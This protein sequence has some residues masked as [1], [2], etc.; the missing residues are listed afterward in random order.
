MVRLLYFNLRCK[1][2][3]FSADFLKRF[4]GSRNVPSDKVAKRFTPMSIPIADIDL[5]SRIFASY[6][7]RGKLNA[8]HSVSINHKYQITIEFI[9]ED[10][11]L[12]PIDIS[13]HCD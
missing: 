5:C 1:V 10:K 9:L 6:S 12:I 11:V 7:M 4:N 13:N 3:N 2:A 8:L